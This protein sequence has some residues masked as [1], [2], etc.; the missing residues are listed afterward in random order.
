MK[1]QQRAFVVEVKQ[2]RRRTGAAKPSI[3]SGTNLETFSREAEADVAKL[4]ATIAPSLA[5]VPIL[6]DVTHESQGEGLDASAIPAGV[7]AS[8]DAAS[9]SAPMGTLASV[10]EPLPEEKGLRM[11]RPRK[12]RGQEQER[13]RE[14]TLRKPAGAVELVGSAEELLRLEEENSRLRQLLRERL[15]EQNAEL[16]AR[17]ARFGE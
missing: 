8:V 12:P 4:F 1:R 16:L 2:S 14:R 6:S 15:I 7:E 3:W 9:A 13:R 10:E 11:R 5:P 17:L